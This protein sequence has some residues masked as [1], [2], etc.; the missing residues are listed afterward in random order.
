M[1][2]VPVPGAVVPSG[3]EAPRIM[4]SITPRI[5]DVDSDIVALEQEFLGRVLLDL[6]EFTRDILGCQ[7][8]EVL[9]GKDWNSLRVRLIVDTVLE[10]LRL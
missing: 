4:E 9:L 1:P 8:P 2:A 5:Y 10:H 6:L 7:F 3:P